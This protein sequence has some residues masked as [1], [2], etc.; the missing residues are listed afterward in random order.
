MT[1]LISVLTSLEDRYEAILRLTL[2]SSEGSAFQPRDLDVMEQAREDLVRQAGELSQRLDPSGLSEDATAA[3]EQ[4][5]ARL[6][7]IVRRVLSA[8]DRRA[9]QLRDAIAAAGNA[10]REFDRGKQAVGQYQRARML[11]EERTAVLSEH[12]PFSG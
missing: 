11:L 5:I 2:D 7:G 12:P 6:V 4:A 10:I 8:D 9:A 3:V 1:D